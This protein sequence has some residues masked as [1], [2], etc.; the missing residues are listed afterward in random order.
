MNPDLFAEI[1]Q[2]YRTRYGFPLLCTDASGSVVHGDAVRTDCSCGGQS[3]DVRLRAAQQT[4][5]FG[6]PIITNC[7]ENGFAMWAAPINDNNRLT[8]AL[9][10]QGIDL[11]SGPENLA[12][13]I[14]EAARGLLDLAIRHNLTNAAAIDQA[15]ASAR[16]EQDRFLAIEATKDACDWDDL[17]S[18]YLREEPPL[19][20]AIRAGDMYEARSILN[21][22]LTSIYAV[23]GDNIEFLKSCILELVVMMN[24]SAVEAGTDP[25]LILGNNYRSLT[26]LSS[27]SDEEDLAVW[28]RNMLDI[29]MEQI[30][31][32][33]RIPQYMMLNKA[34]RYMEAN[35]SQ[36]LKR[37]Q[38]ARLAGMSPSHFSKVMTERM[39]RSF[40][41]VL[42]QLRISRAKQLVAAN[43]Y[44]LSAIAQEC[45]FFDQSHLSR[46]FRKVTGM[47]P[48][49]YRKRHQ[50]CQ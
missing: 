21:R 38:V 31:K 49:S 41:E 15:R 40:S 35:M 43:E 10:V 8:G 2:A 23:A 6:E 33:E 4:L 27:I 42:T 5:A 16:R 44:N 46:T 9:L 26:G 1:A 28:V 48:G 45:G 17:R 25:S 50:N 37:D 24:R 30:R 29:L 18:T 47:S 22:L 3:D 32:G 39:G 13:Q 36:P 12:E 11:E 20:N 19:L 14:E 34:M 7:C